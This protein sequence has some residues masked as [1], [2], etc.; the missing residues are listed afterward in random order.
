M[1]TV[2][3]IKIIAVSISYMTFVHS[4]KHLGLNQDVNQFCF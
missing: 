1:L 4:I 2:V 3:S